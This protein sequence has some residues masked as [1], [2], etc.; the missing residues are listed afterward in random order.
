MVLCYRDR[1]LTERRI[2]LVYDYVSAYL[3]VS[4]RLC[5]ENLLNRRGAEERRD[6]QRK[7]NLARCLLTVT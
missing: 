7:I 2:V 3:C 5:G 6:T 1:T 4:L